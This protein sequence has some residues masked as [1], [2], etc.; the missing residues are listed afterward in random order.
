MMSRMNLKEYVE[1]IQNFDKYT[2][3]MF[4]TIDE[5]SSVKAELSKL[6][7]S[8][9]SLASSST[10]VINHYKSE[11]IISVLD[12]SSGTSLNHMFVGKNICNVIYTQLAFMQEDTSNML[13][14]RTRIRQNVGESFKLL[15]KRNSEYEVV[16][17]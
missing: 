7:L 11:I 5:F 12:G 10:C 3:P 17:L 13:W 4:V 1:S 16:S 2:I 8:F 14:L 9:R 6:G 15:V